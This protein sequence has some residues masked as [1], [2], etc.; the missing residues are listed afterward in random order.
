M[1][2]KRIFIIT[3]LMLL[4]LSLTV[5]IYISD[6]QYNHNE[7]VT[8]SN[9][10]MV[11]ND[12]RA[13]SYNG[14]IFLSNGT[15]DYNTTMQAFNIVVTG[16]G[17]L[18]VGDSSNDSIT[19][20]PQT[21]HTVSY[22]NI[23]ENGKIIIT[24][25]TSIISKGNLSIDISGNGGLF[26]SNGGNLTA[27]KNTTIT[28]TDNGKFIF[29]GSSKGWFTGNTELNVS[30]NASLMIYKSMLHILPQNIHFN[31]NAF[32]VDDGAITMGNTNVAGMSNTTIAHAKLVNLSNGVYK[33]IT[34]TSGTMVSV[35]GSNVNS[36]NIQ[37]FNVSSA[38]SITIANSTA[39]NLNLNTV[40]VTI[41]SSSASQDAVVSNI[42]IN[43][44]YMKVVD[45]AIFNLYIHT[46]R[47][48]I[49]E[50]STIS[51]NNNSMKTITYIN[52][53]I[54]QSTNFYG[55]LSF[56]NQNV[57]LVNSSVNYIYISGSS[58][59]A[60]YNW[61]NS[62]IV[63]NSV[64][65][66]NISI[67]G[68]SRLTLWRWLSIHV[69]NVKGNP[70]PYAVVSIREDNPNSTAIYI[71]A[72]KYGVA[73]TFLKSEIWSNATGFTFVFVGHY[74]ITVN[75]TGYQGTTFLVSI[76]G[77]YSK[78]ITLQTIQTVTNENIIIYLV[79]GLLLLAIVIAAIYVFYVKLDYLHHK[80]N[81]RKTLYHKTSKVKEWDGKEKNN[82]TKKKEQK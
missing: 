40:N 15:Y 49:F 54:A 82:D 71:H 67:S 29:K 65:L 26:L 38:S 68:N 76:T 21:G 62:K 30:N 58:T 3:V 77:I 12:V 25:G 57:T 72:D 7:G 28:I 70:I 35:N 60:I 16:T 33:N 6:L 69:S 2:V 32:V 39:S 31:G 51:G 34:V 41:G 81:K 44:V 23:S 63:N 52:S 36:T 9:H 78:D 79:A 20:N 18:H 64:V 17:I 56:Y 48:A 73:N 46:L 10:F 47:K 61:V 43:A 22:M 80:W 55:V 59:V 42:T 19:L 45:S 53:L 74:I 75:A 4:L 13:I 50:N 14:T 66:T 24:N 5:S 27:Y 11:E 8:F 1:P 37:Y